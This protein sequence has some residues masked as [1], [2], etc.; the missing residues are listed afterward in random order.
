MD[1]AAADLAADKAAHAALFGVL[2]RRHAANVSSASLAGNDATTAAAVNAPGPGGL[3]PLA[4]A[5]VQGDV[6]GADCLLRFGADPAAE[7]DLWDLPRED[8]AREDV[9]K[10]K[11]FP[12]Y[13]AARQTEAEGCA[14]IV[15]RL[16]ACD[17]V[18]VNQATSDSGATAL[19]IACQVGNLRAVKMMLD[20]GGIDVNAA[21][22]DGGDTPLYTACARGHGAVAKILLKQNEVE[23]NKARTDDGVTPL[24]SA[25][26]CGHT[27]VVKMLLAHGGIEVNKQTTANDETSLYIAANGGRTDVVRMLLADGRTNVH[28][29]EAENET[30]LHTAAWRGHLLA[31]Q[32]LIVHGA[33][34]TAIDNDGDTPAAAASAEGK[35]A[36]AEWLTAVSGWSQL[37]VAAGC[38][39]HE[40]AAVALRLGRIDPDWGDSTGTSTAIEEMLAAI[41]TA[42]AEPTGLPWQDAT[43]ICRE[44]AKLVVAATR[45]WSRTT[46]WLHHANVRE[47]VFAVLVAARRL[48]MNPGALAALEPASDGK[49]GGASTDEPAAP[50]VLPIEMWLYSMRFFKRSW[51]EADLEGVRSAK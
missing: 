3:T 32:L 25:C 42:N 15:Q 40:D 47:A 36:L 24:F 41:V 44:T 31:A 19:Y 33:R 26:S 39:L 29:G 17:G 30:P 5:C 48:E 10:W 4:V 11:A 21:R 43:P 28:K 50:A 35:P 22:T 37:R 18:G 2:R 34:L 14:T 45:G 49:G 38:R 16:L 46:H 7:C 1:P 9:K 6:A 13:I 8:V 12:L 20:C 51:W 23:V 27:E